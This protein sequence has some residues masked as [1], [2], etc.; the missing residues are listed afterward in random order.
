[1]LIAAS[2]I[3]TVAFGIY[4]CGI[5]WQI[6]VWLAFFGVFCIALVA[7]IVIYKKVFGKQQTHFNNTLDIDG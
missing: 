1:M 2:G 6:L 4:L 7:F 3:A 5:K